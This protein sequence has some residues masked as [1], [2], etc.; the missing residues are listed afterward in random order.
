MVSELKC[1]GLNENRE[2]VLRL[3]SGTSE[4]ALEA[5]FTSGYEK[6]RIYDIIKVKGVLLYEKDIY[7]ISFIFY[8]HLMLCN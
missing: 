5:R 1:N 7:I 4:R 8:F 3:E 2:T 6:I